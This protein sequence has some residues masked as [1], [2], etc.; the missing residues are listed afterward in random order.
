MQA[1][2]LQAIPQGMRRNPSVGVVPARVADAVAVLQEE[3]IEDMLRGLVIA[4]VCQN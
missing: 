1:A 2:S 3:R 4:L